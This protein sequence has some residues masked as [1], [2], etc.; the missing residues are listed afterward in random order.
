MSMYVR[1]IGSPIKPITPCEVRYGSEAVVQLGE[2][3][4]R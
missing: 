1:R 2:Q 4:V 3:N